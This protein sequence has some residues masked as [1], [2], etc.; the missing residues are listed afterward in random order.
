MKLIVG[1]GN[2]GR[3]YA[4]TR[5]NVGFDVV[6]RFAYRKALVGSPSDFDRVARTKFDGLTLDGNVSLAGGGSEKVLLLK[7]LTYMNLSGRA[8]QAAMAFYQLSPPDVMI[9]LDDVAPPCGQR[10]LRTGGNHRG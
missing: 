8:V 9:V 2:P 3:E 1:L 7:P 10:R 4:S 5:H 6:D